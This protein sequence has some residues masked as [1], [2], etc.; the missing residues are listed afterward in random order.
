MGS[1]I[2]EQL[3]PGEY[4]IIPEIA[5]PYELRMA[6]RKNGNGIVVLSTGDGIYFR[7]VL[8]INEPWIELE[9]AKH[10]AED[11]GFQ[12]QSINVNYVVT[13]QF[14]PDA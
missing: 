13:V 10:Q 7:R 9:L 14:K 2:E 8:S 11:C 3:R 4:R 12:T 5:L 6:S 1:S